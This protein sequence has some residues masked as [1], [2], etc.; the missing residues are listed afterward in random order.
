MW[1]KHHG[2]FNRKGAFLIKLD[3][4]VFEELD[5]RL[6]RYF[7]VEGSMR[8]GRYVIVRFDSLP[9]SRNIFAIDVPHY[10]LDSESSFDNL[11]VILSGVSEHSTAT[12]YPTPG[13]P[14]ALKKAHDRVVFTKDRLYLLENTLR[15]NLPPEVYDM[16]KSLEI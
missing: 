1:L 13:Y 4:E 2:I 8:F 12:S 11:L 6:E 7:G 5:Y 14:Y 15:R 3:P 10:Y 9:G 16:L